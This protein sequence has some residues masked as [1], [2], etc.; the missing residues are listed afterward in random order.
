MCDQGEEE[1]E[2]RPS[3]D[4]PLFVARELLPFDDE[5]IE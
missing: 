1:G 2:E 3:F 5:K 4:S